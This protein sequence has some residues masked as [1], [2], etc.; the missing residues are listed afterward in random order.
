MIEKLESVYVAFWCVVMPITS[1]LIVPSIQGTV[2]AYIL[3]FV[4][5]VFVLIKFKTDGL[6]EKN[7]KYLYLLLS[8]GFAWLLLMVGS[9]LGN[10]I[11]GRRDFP[12]AS[13]I[14]DLDE[15]IVF[16]SA[17]F[18]Q[19]L[20]LGAC[21]LIFLYFRLYF[22]SEWMKYVFW[23]A[24]LMA[25][26]GVY[27][28]VYYLIFKQPGDFIAN[29]MYGEDH[30][31]SWSQ[32]MEVGGLSLLRIK[33]FYGEP[34]FYSSAI[35]LYLMAAINANRFW[36]ICL[37]IFN[38]LFSTSTTCYIGL[39]VCLLFH[40]ILSPKGR[41]LGICLLV[42]MIGAV[43]TISCLVPDT[44]N[45]MF[46]DKISGAN[47]S[48]EMRI[49]A[50]YDTMQLLGGF[51][52]M[53]WLFGIGFGYAY[54][55]VDTAVLTNTGVIGVIIFWWAFL[56]PVVCLPREGIAGAYKTAIFGVFFLFNLTL[57]ELFLPT[58]WMFL[59]LAYKALDEYRKPHEGE[60]R[61]L[62]GELISAPEQ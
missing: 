13:L 46:T 2:P 12:G 49:Q 17:L 45:G 32:T 22:R 52:P 61:E 9:Q 48:G 4:S 27:E 35:I 19:S 14:N 42:L 16:R 20:Y 33:S 55:Q 47:E 58:T 57:S 1:F 15:K 24:Y 5:L 56:K 54:N 18:T 43:V 44:F 37:L 39:G 7:Q 11:D 34:S 59:G 38:G 41:A 53:N 31:G 10:I 3:G 51:S 8:V 23:G 21:V 28:W 60:D 30:P 62:S 36:L 29:R 50:N 6:N 26:Y 25:A 40:S